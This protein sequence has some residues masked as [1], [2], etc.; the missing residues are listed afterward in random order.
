MLKHRITALI[1]SVGL[2]TGLMSTVSV[3]GASAAEHCKVTVTQIRA[4]ELQDGDGEDEIR[5]ELGDD[6]YGTF[7]FTDNQYRTNSM[8]HPNED[9]SGSTV[10]FEIGDR[11]YPLTTTID[12]APLSCSDGTHVIDLEGHGAGY[13]LTYVTSH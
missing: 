5:F 8:G 13:E 9:T 3:V 7:T 6:T 10:P 12:S 11:D 4:F 2:V 1:A